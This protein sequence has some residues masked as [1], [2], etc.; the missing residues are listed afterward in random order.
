M[1]RTGQNRQIPRGVPLSSLTST[2]ASRLWIPICLLLFVALLGIIQHFQIP[3]ALMIGQ[4]RP[5]AS[6]GSTHV[7]MNR[8]AIIKGK[9]NGTFPASDQQ[10]HTQPISSTPHSPQSGLTLQPPSLYADNYADRC[11]P[12]LAYLPVLAFIDDM[13]INK[14]ITE[15][16]GSYTILW[17]PGLEHSLAKQVT[18]VV[19]SGMTQRPLGDSLRK[20]ESFSNITVCPFLSSS[21]IIIPLSSLS[22][23]IDDLIHH[24]HFTQSPRCQR[25]CYFASIPTSQT[26]VISRVDRLNQWSV[27][28]PPSPFSQ[29]QCVAPYIPHSL[30]ASTFKGTTPGS[31]SHLSS[32]H[33][34]PASSSKPPFPQ[35]ATQDNPEDNGIPDEQEASPGKLLMFIAVTVALSVVIQR[36]TLSSHSPSPHPSPKQQV[37]SPSL[38]VRKATSSSV[39]HRPRPG[40]MHAH[41]SHPE[42]VTRES[43]KWE[44]DNENREWGDEKAEEVE[45]EKE[46]GE[47][48]GAMGNYRMLRDNANGRVA[49][50]NTRHGGEGERG[51]KKEREMHEGKDDEDENEEGDDNER[52]TGGLLAVVDTSNIGSRVRWQRLRRGIKSNYKQA[53]G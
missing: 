4:W 48:V 16:D 51:E 31:V 40:Y 26:D 28:C 35:S 39:S 13:F 45:E 17:Q 21:T 12:V 36:M 20:E 3:K 15:S 29:D 2:G 30:P 10:R 1:A 24:V 32:L 41:A 22:L 19:N 8:I 47:W 50:M 38:R 52:A 33:Y 6:G 11:P 9:V 44:N 53:Y 14:A 49:R 27:V 46:E 25:G 23:V 5:R 43:R 42:P 37:S 7:S 34:S 18:V